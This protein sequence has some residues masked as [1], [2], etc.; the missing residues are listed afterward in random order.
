MFVST[1]RVAVS[2][3]ITIPI[4][5]FVP[6]ITLWICVGFWWAAGY[7]IAFPFMFL[8]AWNYMRL[9]MK[10]IGTCNFI[11]PKNRKKIR[12]LRKLRGSIFRRLDDMIE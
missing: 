2:A 9:F 5:L 7:F 11:A 10:F 3:L 4:C 8:L 12:E 6:V 1:F